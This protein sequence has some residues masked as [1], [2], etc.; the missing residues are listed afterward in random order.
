MA[1]LDLLVVTPVGLSMWLNVLAGSSMR[2]PKNTGVSNS[3]CGSLTG[4]N[5][6]L[7]SS[8]DP[9]SD[10]RVWGWFLLWKE[11]MTSVAGATKL[12]LLNEGV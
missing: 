7:N 3:I 4:F 12:G 5:G 6:E 2:C 11:R 9:K 1:V 10:C 8:P